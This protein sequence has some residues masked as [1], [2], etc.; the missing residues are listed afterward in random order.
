MAL[1]EFWFSF[2]PNFVATLV[3]GTIIGTILVWLINRN[4]AQ[5]QRNIEYYENKIQ[6][7]EKAQKY[8]SIIREEIED[9]L[10]VAETIQKT[11]NPSIYNNFVRLNIDYWENEASPQQTAGYL[12]ASSC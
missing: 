8:F 2:V 3:A 6:N 10:N 9:I 7:A 12:T 11:K 5:R 4:Q 1:S